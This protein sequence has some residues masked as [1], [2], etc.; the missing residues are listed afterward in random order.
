MSVPCIFYHSNIVVFF[1]NIVSYDIAWPSGGQ[2]KILSNIDNDG[3]V[4]SIFDDRRIRLNPPVN[5][6][7]LIGHSVENKVL[8]F[9]LISIISIEYNLSTYK[10]AEIW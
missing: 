3:L 7:S 10:L 1:W 4:R 6:Y 5:V 9:I 2:V 8:F